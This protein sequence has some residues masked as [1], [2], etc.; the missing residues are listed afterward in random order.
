MFLTAKILQYPDNERGFLSQGLL[1]EVLLLANCVFYQ[2]PVQTDV[3]A[4]SSAYHINPFTPIW[5]EILSRSLAVP[6]SNG[7][8]TLVIC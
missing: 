7:N 4:V 3:Q 1:K 8:E 2:W 6:H 5:A